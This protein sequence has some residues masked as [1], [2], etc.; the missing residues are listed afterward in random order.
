[1]YLYKLMHKFHTVYIF[2]Y[3]NIKKILYNRTHIHILTFFKIKYLVYQVM[4]LFK[5][6]HMYTSLKIFCITFSLSISILHTF[7]NAWTR[8]MRIE[9]GWLSLVTGDARAILLLRRKGTNVIVLRPF[10][11]ILSYG[12]LCGEVAIKM[13]RLGSASVKSL[14]LMMPHANETVAYV[15]LIFAAN[16]VI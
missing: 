13:I 2:Y 16:R 4:G 1:M 12:R 7:K 11:A 14:S 15:L 6:N 9:F 3:K 5:F 10:T 8:Y